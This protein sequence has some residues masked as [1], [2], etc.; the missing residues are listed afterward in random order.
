VQILNKPGSILGAFELLEPASPPEKRD[1]RQSK[2]GAYG[3]LDPLTG[4]FNHSL[5]QAHLREYLSL[6]VVYPVP[7][8]VLCFSVDAL[9][10]IR[11][12]YGQAAVDATVRDVVQAIESSLRPT[13]YMGRWL[14][15]EFLVILTECNENDVASVANRLAKVVARSAYPGG[16][17]SFAP[18]SPSARLSCTIWTLSA[19]WSVAP[20]KLY[21]TASLRVGDRFVVIAP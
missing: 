12:R 10:K 20:N 9:A 19:P 16:E 3:C 5:I 15:Q 4:A 8:C 1:V 11:E 21:A 13:D 7:F 14:G 18:P 2:L 17:A 6:Y